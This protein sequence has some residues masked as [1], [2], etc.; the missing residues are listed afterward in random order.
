M[1]KR[2]LGRL[3]LQVIWVD[4]YGEIP[5]LLEEIGGAGPPAGAG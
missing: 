3:G 2:V 1:K 5:G 4:D